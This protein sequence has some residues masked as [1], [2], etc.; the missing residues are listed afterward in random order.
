MSKEANKNSNNRS[1]RIITSNYAFSLPIKI[2]SIYEWRILG[3]VMLKMQA[4]FGDRVFKFKKGEDLIDQK[5]YLDQIR[6]Q[7]LSFGSIYRQPE[8]EIIFP[9]DF[10]LFRDENSKLQ[11]YQH[12]KKALRRLS[13]PVE[14]E[15]QELAKNLFDKTRK[16]TGIVWGIYQVIEKPEIRKYKGENYVYFRVPEKTWEVLCHWE[17]GVHIFELSAFFKFERAASVA[18]YILLADYRKKGQVIWPTY[19][20]K[21]IMAPGEYRDYSSFRKKVLDEVAKDLR[22][23]SPF[24][25]E[26]N[27]FVDSECLTPAGKGRGKPAN[28]IKIDIMYQ[29]DK[30]PEVDKRIELFREINTLTPFKVDDLSSEEKTF[31]V[32]SLGFTEIKGKNLETI[33]KLKYYKNYGHEGVDNWRT[34]Q[35]NYFMAYLKKLYDTI[36]L[37]DKKINSIPAYAIK[38]MQE[39]LATYE[40]SGKT[41]EQLQEQQDA[42]KQIEKPSFTPSHEQDLAW[43]DELAQDREWKDAMLNTLKLKND[44]ILCG[45]LM[46]FRD[47]NI[48]HPGHQS[49]QDLSRHFKFSMI[50]GDNRDGWLRLY[51][52]NT[53]VG[54]TNDNLKK[55]PL[56]KSFGFRVTHIEPGRRVYWEEI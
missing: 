48:C 21:D 47:E 29:P 49:K 44:F 40:P 6:M 43:L 53:F 55:D 12:V 36:M 37:S 42:P 14:Y 50:D 23:H 16:D 51:G 35:G 18:L 52:R 41:P 9:L 28:Y 33:V 24:Y 4:D 38:S 13:R 31:L 8:I 15:N 19:Y 46:M 11:G 30:N 22:E 25:V 20:I 1:D 39:V 2:K 7:K 32:T 26:Y 27:E 54:E 3:L 10:L 56:L 5:P 45:Y 34:N 17:K